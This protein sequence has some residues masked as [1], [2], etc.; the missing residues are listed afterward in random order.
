MTAVPTE[1]N[2]TPVRTW[3]VG[4][5]TYTLGGLVL[6]F[7][8]LLLGDFALSIRD[9][10][11]PPLIQ[12]LFHQ[13][14]ASDLLTG[15]VFSSVPAFLGIFIGPIVSYKSD[16]LRSRWGRRLPFLIVPIPI[17][18]LATM[19]LAF[20]PRLGGSVSHLLGRWSPGADGSVLLLISLCWILFEAACFAGY[21]VFA[22]LIND[23]VPQ[24]MV[25]RF[26]GL[27]RAVSLI[28]GMIFFFH[29]FG[30]VKEHATTVFL[31]IGLLYGV[32]LIVMCLAVR[33]GSYPPVPDNGTKPGAF[34]A[35]RN[36]FRQGFSNPYYLW[37]FAATVLGGLSSMPFNTYAIFYAESVGLSEDGYGKCITLTY[38][39]SFFLAYPLGSLADRFHPL[40]VTLVGQAVY[41]A[42]M[43]AGGLL[44][45]NV[46]TF[47]VAL[48]AHGVISGSVF[49]AWASL[50]QRLL[51]RDKFAEIGSAGGLIGAVAGIAIGPALGEFLDF[52]H[53]AYR[54]TF[55]ASSALT[56]LSL[57]AFV[58]LHR[59]FLALG[60]PDHYVA[61]E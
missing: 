49:T 48:V 32:A 29:L 22:A 17:V 57:W 27:F 31:G 3:R 19:G 20:S 34:F 44:V 35:V 10:A 60:G 4:A 38:A 56:I 9:R 12:I 7:C 51:P 33:E 24:A 1:P 6:L 8:W 15:L 26:Y 58:V 5:L 2:A 23:V 55:L 47:S 39:C 30:E 41:A 43:L 59:R 50:P 61:P 42:V 54:F 13:F 52:T 18:V 28:A 37:F 46:F 40:R 36:Y 14:G 11:V 25:G 21:A 16:R 45:H 53:H